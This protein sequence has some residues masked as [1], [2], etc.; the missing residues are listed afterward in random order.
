MERIEHKNL[1]DLTQVGEIETHYTCPMHTEIIFDVANF[2]SVTGKGVSGQVQTQHIALG[3][4][5]MMH[6]LVIDTSTMSTEIDELRSILQLT[7]S[8]LAWLPSRTRS[9]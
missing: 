2:V 6:E 7:I 4:Q 9:I 3:N 5:A 1:S 8:W